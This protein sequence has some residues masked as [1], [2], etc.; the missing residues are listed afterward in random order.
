MKMTFFHTKGVL[1][2]KITDYIWVS[3]FHQIMRTIQ[4]ALGFHTIELPCDEDEGGE[5]INAIPN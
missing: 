5:L 4:V 2:K 1:V 3:L